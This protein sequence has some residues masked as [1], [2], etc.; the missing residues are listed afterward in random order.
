MRPLGSYWGEGGRNDDAAHTPWTERG[1]D[2]CITGDQ[3]INDKAPVSELHSCKTGDR[4]RKSGGL[5]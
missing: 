2:V 1:R 4:D 5:H 3:R